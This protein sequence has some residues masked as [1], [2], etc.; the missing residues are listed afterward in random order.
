MLGS[1][2]RVDGLVAVVVVMS[3]ML[4]GGGGGLDGKLEKMKCGRQLGRDVD[5]DGAD[6]GVVFLVNAW[7]GGAGLFAWF[8]LDGD[9]AA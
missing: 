3:V 7:L 6:D 4:A 9:D 5:V 8:A 2:F 1:E